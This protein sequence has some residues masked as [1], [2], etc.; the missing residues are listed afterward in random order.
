MQR[1]LTR[2]CFLFCFF[3][4][5][6]LFSSFTAAGKI[7]LVFF[8]ASIGPAMVGEMQPLASFFCPI[9]MALMTDPVSTCDGYSYERSSIESWLKLRPSSPLTGALLPSDHLVPNLALR[10][11]IQEWQERHVL[12]VPRHD[13]EME[14]QP[15]SA[16]SSQTL[17]IGHLRLRGREAE[18]A[19]IKVAVLKLRQDDG[20]RETGVMLRV[21]RHPRLVRYMGQ[22]QDAD[23]CRL[24]LTEYAELGSLREALL[25]RLAGQV[26]RGHQMAIMQQIAQGME[27][28]AEQRVVHRDLAARHVLVMGFDKEDVRRTSVKVAGFGLA[29]ELVD[30][31]DATVAGRGLPVRYMPP[32]SMQRGR[33]SEK[34][35]V[36]AYGVTSWEILTLGKTPYY[37]MM[38]ESVIRYVCGGG[39][40]PRE[41]IVGGCPDGLWAVR[42]SCW[43]TREGDRPTFAELAVAVGRAGAEGRGRAAWRRSGRTPGLQDARSSSQS[44]CRGLCRVAEAAWTRI[45]EAAGGGIEAVATRVRKRKYREHA[46]L[47]E[48]ACDALEGM[49]SDA[50]RSLNTRAKRLRV[51]A[52]AV[53]EVQ[54]RRGMQ[55]PARE[56]WGQLRTTGA[57]DSI[58]AVVQDMTTYEALAEVQQAGCEA[59]VR[60]AQDVEDSKLNASDAGLRS[61][62][63][64]DSMPRRHLPPPSGRDQTESVPGMPSELEFSLLTTSERTTSSRPWG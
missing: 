33:C 41:D 9:S 63:L 29:V 12:L 38:D 46:G 56:A 11:A 61:I 22:S 35:D 48:S 15:I 55:E 62:F 53:V 26:T 47:Q 7:W 64:A 8:I 24:L 54:A 28:L 2:V 39:R 43:A 10:S 30:G 49:A 50:R 51:E 18:P 5:D 58:E 34:S 59:L 20:E 3:Y 52:S 19:R 45:R 32:E 14:R 21:R 40:L 37:N 6:L 23:G 1:R 36:W 44:L 27:H 60:M 31:T 16:G 4:E 13:V 42:E 17:Y 25:G 57:E